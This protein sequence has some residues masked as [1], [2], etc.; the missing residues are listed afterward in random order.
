M[1]FVHAIVAYH[2]TYTAGYAAQ[3]TRSG[4]TASIIFIIHKTGEKTGRL[5]SL[6]QGGRTVERS[7]SLLLV[8][9][10][11]NGIYPGRVI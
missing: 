7:I 2:R 5:E 6:F 9:R 10:Q 4:I 11:R 3:K 8:L 1:Q